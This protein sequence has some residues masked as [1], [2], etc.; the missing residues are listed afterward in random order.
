MGAAVQRSYTLEQIEAGLT[1]LAIWHGNVRQAERTLA[2][3]GL[4]IPKSTLQDWKTIH[5]DRLAELQEQIVP[6]VRAK[7]A[8]VHEVISMRAGELTLKGL[9]RF[10]DELSKL[11][12]RDLAAAIRNISTTGAIAV[13]KASLL[14]GMPTEIRQTDS[15]EEILKRLEQKHPGMFVSKQADA[16]IPEAEVVEEKPAE[17]AGGAVIADAHGR[18]R[19]GAST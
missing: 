7:L 11:E 13:D 17:G 4:E 15:A 8:E 5:A 16:D 18:K 1:E 12:A 2:E 3:R 9:D 19:T 6:Q 10:G 14:R